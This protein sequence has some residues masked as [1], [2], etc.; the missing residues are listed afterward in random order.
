MPARPA[1]EIARLCDEIRHHD[2]KYYVEAAPEI[3]DLQYD[4]LVERLKELEAAHPE[5][6]APDSP[7]QRV[8][9]QPVEGLQQVAHRVPMLSI[10]NTYSL[11]EL[12]QYGARAAKLLPAEEIE[13]VVELKIDG[14]A[15]CARLRK[16]RARSWNHPGQRPRGRRHYP[17]R[18]H[19]GRRPAST[20]RP[21]G[22][23]GARSPRRSLHDQFRPG[24]AQRVAA[25]QG[26]AAV[27]QHAKRHRRQHPPARSADLP[28]APAAALL[29]RG[30]LRRATS[31]SHPYGVSRRASRVRLA[32]HAAR[33]VFR[34]VSPRPSSIANS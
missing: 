20:L 25:P 2:R 7:T 28:R 19:R 4:R 5:L 15:V 13:W 18:P 17:Q 3:S 6:I 26:P 30:G 16:R 12:R 24:G 31:R 27:R 22:A 11:D 21:R 33:R 34:L 32:P 29:P 9:D 1:D 8:G 14:V 23:A 10:E